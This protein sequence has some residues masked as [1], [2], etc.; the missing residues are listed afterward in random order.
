MALVP[1]HRKHILSQAVECCAK[2]LAR[3]SVVTAQ[4]TDDAKPERMHAAA[5]CLLPTDN[6]AQTHRHVINLIFHICRVKVDER[7]HVHGHLPSVDP[8]LHTH[9]HA[10]NELMH[11]AHTSY[12]A[13]FSRLQAQHRLRSRTARVAGGGWCKLLLTGQPQSNPNLH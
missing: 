5:T 7:A 3:T 4:P 6:V 10:W 2:C 13:M 9:L 11:R 1:V 8:E 12:T